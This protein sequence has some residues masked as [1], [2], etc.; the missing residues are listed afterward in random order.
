[1]VVQIEGDETVLHVMRRHTNKETRIYT[2]INETLGITPIIITPAYAPAILL[3]DDLAELN[4]A[5]YDGVRWRED[6]T[7]EKKIP[8]AVRIMMKSYFNGRQRVAAATIPL[9]R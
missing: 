8:R 5:C 1:M 9:T 2:A 3:S 7:E 6:W 4:V